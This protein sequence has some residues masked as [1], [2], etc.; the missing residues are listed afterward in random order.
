[1]Y[2]KLS[3]KTW[4]MIR[5]LPFN[6]Q[7]PLFR[8]SHQRQ[9]SKWKKEGQPLPPP[10]MIKEGTIKKYAD[11]TC[12]NILVE[13]GTYLGDMVFAQL[14]NFKKIYSIELDYSLWKKAKKRFRNY[15]HVSIIQGDSGKI[16]NRVLGEINEPAIF[17]LD[18]HYSGGITAQGENVTPI[19]EELDIIFKSPFNHVLLIDDARL[20]NGQNGYPTMEELE[21]YIFKKKPACKITVNDDCIQM[22]L[23]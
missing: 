18:G 22:M 6:I 5:H 15:P 3:E 10:R 8:I 17:W 19:F 1:M 12:Y 14:N 9:L 7:K 20:F 2:Q 16:L 21:N 11:S 4:D 13:S 23:K